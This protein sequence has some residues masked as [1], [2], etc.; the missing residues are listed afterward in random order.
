MTPDATGRF[1]SGHDT[2]ATIM[3]VIIAAAL[4][5]TGAVRILVTAAAIVFALAVG[6]SRVYLGDHYPTDVVGSYLTV[7][8]SVL[9]ASA[10]TDH[11]RR[12][13][14]LPPVPPPQP[15]S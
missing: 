7:A 1:P 10:L 13:R 5:G 8:A 4:I 2:T 9:L 3:V 15:R 12:P 11:P 6:V 14:N